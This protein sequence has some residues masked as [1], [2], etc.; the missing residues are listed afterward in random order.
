MND[1]PARP[2]L[3]FLARLRSFYLREG[4]FA[5]VQR[6]NREV[7]GVLD[8]PWLLYSGRL[9]GCTN[10]SE[11]RVFALRRS[12]HHAILNWLMLQMKGRRCFLNDCRPNENPFVGCSRTRSNRIASRIVEHNHL[13][14]QREI[15]GGLS[16]KGV[17]IYNYEDLSFPEVLTDHFEENRTAWLGTSRHR[18]DVLVLRDP[19]N[20]F[21]SKLRW[22]YGEKHTPTPSS[23]PRFIQYWKE[24]AKEFLG[25]TS[26]LKHKVTISYNTWFLD[27]NY[28]RE[29]ARKFNLEFND[30]GI[31]I[32]A[33]WGPTRWGD[34]FDGTEYDGKATQ[35]QVLDRWR[36]YT[37][38]PFYRNLF[39]DPEVW[40]LSHRIFGSI[41]GTEELFEKV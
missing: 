23:F 14:W 24:Y 18:Y 27:Q 21:A 26:Y 1:I 29:L 28:R 20:L 10:E 30:R 34:S 13:F 33:K 5:C 32:V 38:D 11:M 16:K 7:L 2:T 6:A 3:G 19:F 35:M 37:D 12:G 31:H 36:K 22:A 40:Q 39:A 25:D 8:I 4:F 17:L 9:P 15:A 41:P